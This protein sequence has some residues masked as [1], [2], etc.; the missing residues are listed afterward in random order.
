MIDETEDVFAPLAAAFSHIHDSAI[1]CSADGEVVI[2]NAGAEELFGYTFAEAQ[3][4]DVC[5]LCPPEQSADTLKLFARALSGQPVAPGD[6][7]HAWIEG[8]GAMSV[9]VR[10]HA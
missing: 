2:W 9:P 7:M 3:K 10:A 1:V 8:V 6:V 4:K 5:F